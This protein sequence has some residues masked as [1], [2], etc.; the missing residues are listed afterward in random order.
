M[1]T[2]NKIQKLIYLILVTAIYFF[3]MQ[4]KSQRA[5]IGGESFSKENESMHVITKLSSDFIAGKVM[6]NWSAINMN[7]DC[8]YQVERS[9][10]AQ[11]YEIIGLVKGYS[12]I[13]SYELIYSFVD[14]KP[15]KNNSYYKVSVKSDPNV[16]AVSE[17]LVSGNYSIQIDPLERVA[18]K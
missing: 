8:I 7:T 15:L 9:E 14:K 18:S 16:Q 10:N 5:P 1:K 13:G 11:N 2:K 17:Q 3:P 12:T 6:I 4:V